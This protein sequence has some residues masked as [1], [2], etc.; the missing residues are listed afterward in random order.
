[1][2]RV[3]RVD[4]IKA[5]LLDY[6]DGQVGSFG[7]EA[8]QLVSSVV[9]AHDRSESDEKIDTLLEVLGLQDLSYEELCGTLRVAQV[10]RKLLDAS[11][12]EDEV[13]L[14]WLIIEPHI[15]KIKVPE[16]VA[17]GIERDMP[18]RVYV[19]SVVTHPHV[20]AGSHKLES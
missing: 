20:K 2:G 13:N 15:L 19:A 5:C 17:R 10:S 11:P 14:S 18:T 7:H 3:A 16:L 6:I 4:V 9:E 1:M 12:L 8:Q